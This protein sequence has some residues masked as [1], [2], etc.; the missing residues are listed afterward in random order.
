MTEKYLYYVQPETPKPKWEYKYGAVIA[1]SAKAATDQGN[2]TFG[3]GCRIMSG[4]Y[5]LGKEWY[6]GSK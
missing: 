3:S 4:P 1:E 5:K 6:N 2:N